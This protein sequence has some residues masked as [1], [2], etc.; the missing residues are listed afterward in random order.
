MEEQQRGGEW[1]FATKE[2]IWVMDEIQPQ[3]KKL[4]QIQFSRDVTVV[5]DRFFTVK[6]GQI[7]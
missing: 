5:S 3:R 2:S 1:C 4:I 6:L 7:N